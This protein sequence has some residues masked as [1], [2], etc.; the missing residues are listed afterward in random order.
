MSYIY[1]SLV[2]PAPL[3][4]D[5]QML[6]A[7]WDGLDRDM[8]AHLSPERRAEPMWTVS[9]DGGTIDIVPA[10]WAK[11]YGADLN[12]PDTYRLLVIAWTPSEVSEK[13]N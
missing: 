1:A 9:K 5:A 13:A 12:A 7:T 4:S 2:V 6:A 10:T 3:M 11:L 8:P